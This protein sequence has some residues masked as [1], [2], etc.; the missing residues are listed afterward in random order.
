MENLDL[1]LSFVYRE[2]ARFHRN[3]YIIPKL[4]IKSE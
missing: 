2:S 1:P 4:L 3:I